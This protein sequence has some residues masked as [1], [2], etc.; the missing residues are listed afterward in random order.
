[1]FILKYVF[2]VLIFPGALFTI[3]AGWLLAGL[4]RKV[5]ARMQ[6]RVGPPVLQPMY[7]FFKL[8]GKETIVPARANSVAFKLAP[9]ISFLSLSMIMLFIPIFGF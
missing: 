6:R 5:I 8:L 3:L 7:D 9:F 2:Y 4:D 1:M